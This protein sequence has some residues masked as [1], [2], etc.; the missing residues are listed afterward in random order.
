[1]GFGVVGLG[2]RA[3][4]SKRKP[5][6]EGGQRTIEVLRC[7]LGVAELLSTDP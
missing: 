2:A 5:V 3:S 1:M 7:E 4:L 6:P